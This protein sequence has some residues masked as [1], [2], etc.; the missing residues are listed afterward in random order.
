MSQKID[1]NT[2]LIGQIEKELS[3][4]PLPDTPNSLYDPF[5]YALK[6]GGKRVRP[7]MCLLA[8]GLCGGNTDEAIPAALAVEI[9]HNFTLVHDDIMDRADTRRGVESVFHKWDTNKAILSGDVMFSVSMQQLN[10]YG[11]NEKF[12]K[13]D[14]A[15]LN[16]VF[17]NAITTVCE[18]QALDMDFVDRQDVDHD[19]YLNMIAGKTG[20]LLGASLEMGAI[21]AQ[22]GS[23]TR[24]KLYSFGMELGLAFQIQDDLLDATA[25]PEKFGKKLGGD[26]YE[27]KKTY[28]TILALERADGENKAFI[29]QVL[30]DNNPAN[31]SVTKVL[32]MFHQ[33]GVIKDI[34]NE[35]DTHYEKA[36]EI[37]NDFSESP[38]KT[39][40]NN[41]LL[42]LKNRDH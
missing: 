5:R 33:L 3:G 35:V 37:L 12:G 32:E 38:Y 28:L 13:H 24:K 11:S 19:E 22:A 7:F 30:D 36:E 26:I 39:E 42:F 34:S 4:L 17:L 29:Q 31:D 15:A 16:E 14:Y 25:D 40:L 27:G 6:M 1:L 20:A 18:G 9:L 10:Y 21:T 8:N 41:L 23:D 2:S